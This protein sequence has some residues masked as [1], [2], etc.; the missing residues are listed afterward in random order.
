MAFLV[1]D[2]PDKEVRHHVL[3]AL[4]SRLSLPEDKQ[5][6]LNTKPMLGMKNQLLKKA[7]QVNKPHDGFVTNSF[8]LHILC[9]VDIFIWIL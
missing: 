9:D 8:V 4:F 5:T 6:G 1:K 3:H 2:A 7:F